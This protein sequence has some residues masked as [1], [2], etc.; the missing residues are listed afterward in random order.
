MIRFTLSQLLMGM[1][2]IG[3]VLAL[4]L[5]D[6]CGT[7]YDRISY[8]EYTADGSTLAVARHDGRDANVSFKFYLRNVSRTVSLLDVASQQYLGVIEQ[9]LL[10]GDRGPA[11]EEFHYAGPS[12]A[13]LN[14]ETVV[15]AEFGGGEVSNYTITDSGTRATRTAMQPALVVAVNEKRTVLATAW[16]EEVR[17]WDIESTRLLDRFQATDMPFMGAPRIAIA[18][19]DAHF[20]TAGYSG[21]TIRSISPSF[22]TGPSKLVP[23]TDDE[24]FHSLAFTKDGKSI[25]AATSSRL[26]FYNLQG[27][28][29]H[30][31][32]S[33]EQ[34]RNACLSHDN[35]L[36]AVA[37]QNRVA[38]LQRKDFA[39]VI[40]LEGSDYVRALTFAPDSQ[41]IAGVS[42]G[43]VGIWDI[44]TGNL[45]YK[46]KPAGRYRPPW[47]IPLLGFIAWALVYWRVMARRTNQE[48]KYSRDAESIAIT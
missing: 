32:S 13:F 24:D 18:P 16:G 9:Q 38:I 44:R 27:S 8:I 10:P 39:H 33:D 5:S 26:C 30:Q 23:L 4:F 42:R 22:R 34:I 20:A 15:I 1:A 3:L 45:L 40:D 2:L 25:F 41:S 48:H 17:L 46:A 37:T 29:T 11:F 6:G 35:R 36:I 12:F 28:L 21:I 7:H 31:H 47:T 19:D 43:S 14:N